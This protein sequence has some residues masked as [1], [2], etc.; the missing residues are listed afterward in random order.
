[1][2]FTHELNIIIKIKYE[3]YK[4]IIVKALSNYFIIVS[5]ITRTYFTVCTHG[6][7]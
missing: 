6:Q 2:N 1:M 5:T 7:V 4:V 3:E